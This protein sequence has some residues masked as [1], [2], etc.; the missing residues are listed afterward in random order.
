MNG[1]NRRMSSI[2]RSRED[3]DLRASVTVL[4][5]YCI[6]KKKP[7]KKKGILQYCMF[8]TLKNELEL[9]IFDVCGNS[10][11]CDWKITFNCGNLA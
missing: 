5:P 2:R 10:T 1:I 8:T 7:F 6:C 9:W 3:E 4:F 11:E